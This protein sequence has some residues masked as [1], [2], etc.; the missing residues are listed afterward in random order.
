M[1]DLKVVMSSSDLSP[2]AAMTTASSIMFG[3]DV[4]KGRNVTTSGP[5][6][7]GVMASG[8]LTRE[9]YLFFKNTS[10]WVKSIEMRNPTTSYLVVMC[11]VEAFCATLQTLHQA[12]ISSN[13]CGRTTEFTYF[14]YVGNLYL[15]TSCRRCVY[16]FNCLVSLQRFVVVAFPMRARRLRVL[17]QTLPVC[18][19]VL[20]LSLLAHVYLFF[21]YTVKS[22]NSQGY[23]FVATTSLAKS[24]PLLFV[25]IARSIS[26]IMVYI[27]L[28]VGTFT[29]SGMVTALFLHS[30]R[31]SKMTNSQVLP[32]SSSGVAEN[33]SNKVN[34][35]VSRDHLE[36]QTTTVVL[37]STFFFILFSLPNNVNVLVR[38]DL[39]HYGV[40][41]K[42]HYLYLTLKET[43]TIGQ[44]CSDLVSFTSYICLS[45]TFRQHLTIVLWSSFSLCCPVAC[46]RRKGSPVVGT[47]T[48]QNAEV[49]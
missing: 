31:R 2:L 49:F 22:G 29:N 17:N 10:T 36:K 27:P 40:G 16:V 1:L 3:V 7:P 41:Q 43:F 24:Y 30:K 4:I 6:P 19:S 13:S 46:Y 12:C 5:A 8:L 11:V 28:I 25:H 45:S 35:S 44:L 14:V 34:K 21:R 47:S 33:K 23:H 39:D 20:P 26:Y 38:D 48:V 9:D 42:E 18:S 37:V 15:G 32:S